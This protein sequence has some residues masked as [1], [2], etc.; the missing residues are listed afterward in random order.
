MGK[1]L[2]SVSAVAP[3]ARISGPAGPLVVVDVGR[4]EHSGGYGPVD[5]TVLHQDGDLE[6]GSMVSTPW[7]LAEVV[8]QT[9]PSLSPMEPRTGGKLPEHLQQRLAEIERHLSDATPGTHRRD[10]AGRIFAT[11]GGEELQIGEAYA[12][13]DARLWRHAADDIRWL[14]DELQRRMASI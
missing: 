13:G 4:R 6:P 12:E 10:C 14:M 2:P 8:G 11:I 1:Q 3:G 5:L 9:P 7:G